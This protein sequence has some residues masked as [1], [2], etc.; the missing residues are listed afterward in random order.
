MLE[1]YLPVLILIVIGIC[2]AVVISLIS[3]WVGPKHPSAVKNETYECGVPY[4]GSARERFSV[5]FYLTAVLFILFDIESVFLIPWSVVYRKL[6][7]SGFGIFIFM[8]MFVFVLI[9]VAGL[10]Y[11]WKRGA[12]DWD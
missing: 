3:S 5:K 7:Q 10:M 6:V 4:R 9:L 8:E 11:V 12:L 2:L 1:Q